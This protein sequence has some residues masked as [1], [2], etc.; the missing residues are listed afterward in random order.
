MLRLVNFKGWIYKKVSKTPIIL[1]SKAERG[2]NLMPGYRSHW[3]VLKQGRLQLYSDASAAKEEEEKYSL[4]ETTKFE[5]LGKLKFCFALPLGMTNTMNNDEEDII[6]KF[7]DHVQ[8][9]NWYYLVVGLKNANEKLEEV[10]SLQPEPRE[11]LQR[12]SDHGRTP[13][14]RGHPLARHR[15]PVHPPG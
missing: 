1:K 2:Q 15:S 11:P 4:L 9:N 8:R 12:K 3:A 13:G 14:R 5:S 6:F 10:G 7:D